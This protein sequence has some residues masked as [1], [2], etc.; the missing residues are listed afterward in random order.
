MTGTIFKALSGFYY[1]E[2]ENETIRCKARGR[3]R[4][5]KIIPLVGD[6]VVFSDAGDGTGIIDEILP[7]RNFFIRPPVANIDQII[8]VASE[9]IPVT[10]PFLIDRIAAI[11][12]YNN[13]EPVVCINKVDEVPGDKLFD[14]YSKTGFR[15]IKIS[16]ITGLGIEELHETMRGKINALTG[17]SGVGKSSI[18]NALGGFDIQV[19][20]VSEKLGRG[21]H[22]TRH[23]E[24]YKLK[25][26]GIVADTP[27]FSAFDTEVMELNDCEKLQYMFREF[28]QFLSDCRYTGCSHTKE[29]G[30]AVLNAVSRGEISKAR[31]DSY[32]RLYEQAKQYKKWE[33]KPSK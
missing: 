8:I 29:T 4:R 32:V 14:I 25:G 23:V 24:L 30:C 27:G 7:R 19:G 2:T 12:E 9:S 22:T 33:N 21:R 16:A 10:A 5:E 6:K 11:A 17:N 31:H 18:L 1:V 13:C 26:G 20:E 3:F 28:D 15:T